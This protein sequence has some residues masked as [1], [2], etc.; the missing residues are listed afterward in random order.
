MGIL[1]LIIANSPEVL[2]TAITKFVPEGA[3][4][5]PFSVAEYKDRSRPEV[6]ELMN[7]LRNESDTERYFYSIVP[8]GDIE[9][10]VNC[11]HNDFQCAAQFAYAGYSMY[12]FDFIDRAVF[13]NGKA[14]TVTKSIAG[15]DWHQL[16]KPVVQKPVGQDL[17]RHLASYLDERYETPGAFRKTTIHI[18]PING[19][20]AIDIN[21]TTEDPVLVERLV[22]VGFQLKVEA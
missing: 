17:L 12:I 5:E 1:N 20:K 4:V 3:R 9:G 11:M 13:A 21:M 22:K 8:L 19:G 6:I 2:E 10:E 18:D 14:F 7:R 15:P 16:N